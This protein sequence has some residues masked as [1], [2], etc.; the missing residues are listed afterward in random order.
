MSKKK[1]AMMVLL[2]SLLYK[3]QALPAEVKNV[4]VLR[5]FLPL[6]FKIRDEIARDGILKETARQLNILPEALYAEWNKLKKKKDAEPARNSTAANDAKKKSVQKRFLTPEEELLC[7]AVSYPDL[8][9]KFL[10]CSGEHRD[11]FSEAKFR[12]C[13]QILQ[14]IALKGKSDKIQPG[15]FLNLS[16]PEISNWLSGLLMVFS[17]LD[18]SRREEI[19]NSL[20]R[21][22]DQKVQREKLSALRGEVVKNLNQGHTSPD[23]LSD[24]QELVSTIKGGTR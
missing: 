2:Q 3:N 10:E 19:F 4:F 20:V 14:E 9:E 17:K 1:N 15:D 23:E 21:S 18:Q 16:S 24:F 7:L 8:R 11:S 12:E 5:S 13:I 22:I 6:L